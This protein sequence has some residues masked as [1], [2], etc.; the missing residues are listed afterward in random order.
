M[1]KITDVITE[2]DI[3]DIYG[4]VKL[5]KAGAVVVFVGTVRDETNDKQVVSIE[6]ECYK[7]MASP[8]F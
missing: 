2:S 3:L 8:S 4:K 7:E 6:Y 1:I 5:D